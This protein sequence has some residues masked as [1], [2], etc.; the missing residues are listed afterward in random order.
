M[1]GR[2]FRDSRLEFL[3]LIWSSTSDV[4][5]IVISSSL[6]DSFSPGVAFFHILRKPFAAAASSS[7]AIPSPLA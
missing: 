7:C 4:R 2:V 1:R 6:F 3:S 5:V